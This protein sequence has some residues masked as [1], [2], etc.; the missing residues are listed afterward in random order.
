VSGYQ[1]P[2]IA[3][4]DEASGQTIDLSRADAL[5]LLR[6]DPVV[7]ANYVKNVRR[8]GQWLSPPDQRGRLILIGELAQRVLRETDQIPY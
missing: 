5:R 8:S 2:R 6:R 4:H 1:N 7:R 3:A